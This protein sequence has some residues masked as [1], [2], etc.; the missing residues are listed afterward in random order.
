MKKMKKK[1][2]KNGSRTWEKYCTN[3][4]AVYIYSIYIYYYYY[5]YYTLYII[6]IDPILLSIKLFYDLLCFPVISR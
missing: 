2:K 3:I 4:H 5:Y 6:Y 1:R